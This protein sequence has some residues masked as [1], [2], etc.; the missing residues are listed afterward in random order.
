MNQEGELSF[1]FNQEMIV[2]EMD[3]KA[4]LSF[5]V[6]AA[7]DN[8]LVKAVFVSDASEVTKRKRQLDWYNVDRKNEVIDKDYLNKMAALI[9]Q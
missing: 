1:S 7:A 5:T 6:K 2:K 8:S 9:K 4:I 3:Y